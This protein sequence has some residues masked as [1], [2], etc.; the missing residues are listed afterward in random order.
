M[1]IIFPKFSPHAGDYFLLA[2]KGGGVLE[3][4]GGEAG[5]L[6]RVKYK[7]EASHEIV[8]VTTLQ[9]FLSYQQGC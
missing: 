8:S 4:G 5:L 3:G 9:Y 6:E 1:V 7:M 2:L